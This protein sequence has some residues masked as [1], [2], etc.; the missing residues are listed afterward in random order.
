M[1]SEAPRDGV[2]VALEQNPLLFGPPVFPQRASRRCLPPTCLTQFWNR[3]LGTAMTRDTEEEGRCCIFVACSIL[4][5]LF[6]Y[7]S[8]SSIFAAMY[9]CKN[10]NFYN[11]GFRINHYPMVHVNTQMVRIDAAVCPFPRK[12]R[13]TQSGAVLCSVPT[14][15][16]CSRLVAFI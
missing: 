4:F 8:F 12:L 5:Y 6:I 3:P 9:R 2:R 7:E 15:R 16:V 14:W 1:C 11:S 13:A 10:R